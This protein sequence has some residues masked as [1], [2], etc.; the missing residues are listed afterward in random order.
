MPVDVRLWPKADMN[1]CTAHVRFTPKSGHVQRTIACPLWATSG[2]VL[3]DRGAHQN[4]NKLNRARVWLACRT[5]A[6]RSQ[7]PPTHLPSAPNSIVFPLNGT[8]T[9][10][11]VAAL[12]TAVL[13]PGSSLPPLVAI[14]LACEGITSFGLT[15]SL[16]T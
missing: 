4:Q 9:G 6:A 11:L 12:N 7:Q 14:S 16:I 5:R 3:L 15:I 10:T 8:C 13:V 2:Y 1:S